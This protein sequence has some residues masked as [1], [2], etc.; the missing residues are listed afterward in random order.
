M[1]LEIWQQLQNVKNILPHISKLS[2]V[3]AIE[4]NVI[5][6]AFEEQTNKIGLRTT[7]GTISKTDKGYRFQRR[8]RCGAT[9]N[10]K[11]NVSNT[12]GIIN[13]EDDCNVKC[14]NFIE[15]SNFDLLFYFQ[16]TQFK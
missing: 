12:M 6:T 15:P 10:L 2:E 4:L 13:Y 7:N 14:N 11:I 1:S 5:R 3:V 16:K 9:V 8:C